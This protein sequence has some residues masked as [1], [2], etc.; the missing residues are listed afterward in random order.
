AFAGTTNATGTSASF[1]G[2][3][4]LV[5]DSSGNYFVADTTNN[6]IR[7]IT[8]LGVVTTFAGAGGVGAFLDGAGTAAK[9]NSPQGLAIDSANNIYVADFGNNRIRKIDSAGNVT[10]IAGTGTASSLDGAALSATMRGPTGIAVDSTG[11]VYWT[12]KTTSI[13]RKLQG[14]QV[15]TI[16]GSSGL[17]GTTDGTGSVARFNLPTFLTINNAGNLV[18]ND[19][20]NLSYRQVTPAGVVT[21][22]FNYTSGATAVGVDA[23]GNLYAGLSSNT[24]S[25]ISS[26]DTT[27]IMGTGTAGSVI[28]VN[29]A[30]TVGNTGQMVFLSDGTIVI[31]DN[32]RN[33][34]RVG[35]PIPSLKN[36]G[37]QIVV[38]DQLL[39]FDNAALEGL[40]IQS[41]GYPEPL[42]I[43]LTVTKGVFSL[44]Q[45]TGL[46]FTTGD[47]TN[48]ITMTF[49]G[50]MANI[51]AA[52]TG[53][54]YNFDE[55]TYSAI[56]SDTLTISTPYTV[57]GV[58]ST[59]TQVVPIQ[60]V[61]PPVITP[62]ADKVVNLGTAIPAATFTVTDAD[63]AAN[64]L[65]YT[66]TS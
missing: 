18:V 54:V 31:A 5:K 29:T 43:T 44:S 16:A 62:V 22:L 66:I 30:A 55:V 47:G 24:L 45:T 12:D 59:I 63:T 21:T 65:T 46:T 41:N 10:T 25:L 49:T 58:T 4:G 50:S 32:T 11:I 13:I 36:P 28:A 42:S 1:S 34:I 39:T 6:L 52:L 51:N 14:G 7:K 60:I 61:K 56:N 2:P 35:T 27:T 23:Q 20:T 26:F 15:T 3:S 48:D 17:T 64:A 53:L 9:F 37:K 57:G 40:G 33:N 19:A 8:P 38:F